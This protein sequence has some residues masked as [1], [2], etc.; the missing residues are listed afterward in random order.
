MIE[1][2]ILVLTLYFFSL[3]LALFLSFVRRIGT[4]LATGINILSTA[5]LSLNSFI[6][7]KLSWIHPEGEKILEIYKPDTIALSVIGIV[8]IILIGCKNNQN[9]KNVLTGILY[10]FILFISYIFLGVKDWISIFICYKIILLTSYSSIGIPKKGLIFVKKIFPLNIFQT[11]A[12]ILGIF[13]F[14]LGTGDFSFYKVEVANQDFF[15]LSLILFSLVLAIE[16]GLFPFN[17]WP[18]EVL[19]YGR[20]DKVAFMLI[21]RRTIVCYFFIVT[22]QD[23]YTAHSLVYREIILNILKIYILANFIVGSIILLKTKNIINLLSTILITN[24]GLVF[25]AI[26]PT[27][28]EFFKDH[29]FFYLFSMS[30]TLIGIS[31]TIDAIY[32]KE[33]TDYR[34][35]K[36]R[37]LFSYHHGLGLQ[38]SILLLSLICFPPTIGFT[39]KFLFYSNLLGK[40]IDGFIMA[41]I[42][43]SLIPI[44]SGFKIFNFIFL[45]TDQDQP[46]IELSEKRHQGIRYIVVFLVII[47][48]I[49]PSL[50][51]E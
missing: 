18:E 20:I 22:I 25:L 29:L 1:N 46:S 42:V 26:G 39:G 24:M 49:V 47:G 28:D 21:A 4:K 27:R 41:L 11:T 35:E 23:L 40:N 33:E 51:L 10:S 17:T 38:L 48:G 43:L 3:C 45:K 32:P 44:Q 19:K 2:G 36:L 14:F 16:L 5:L 9:R 37:G 6:V 31:F 50:F 8:I 12:L 13:F 15:L 30:I 34:L 7:P